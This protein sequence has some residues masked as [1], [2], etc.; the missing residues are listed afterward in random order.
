[1]QRF[2]CASLVSMAVMFSTSAFAAEFKYRKSVTLKVG[3]S[4]ILK[5]IRSAD[6]SRAAPSW[7]QV[8][9]HIPRSK[10]GTF[11]NGGA[12]TTKSRSCDGTVGARGVKF[13]AKNAGSERLVVA[14]DPIR[15]RVK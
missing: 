14:D 15:I 5:G 8:R 4:I 6:C 13:T 3:Q 12:G 11:S 10:L 1:M 9:H 2:V 7:G